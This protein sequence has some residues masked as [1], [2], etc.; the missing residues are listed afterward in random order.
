MPVRVLAAYVV[1][2][3]ARR[4]WSTCLTLLGMTAVV[5]AIVLMLMLARGLFTR[6]ADT[7]DP[8]NLLVI[9]KTGQSVILSSL[10]DEELALLVSLPQLARDVANRPLI[11]PELVQLVYVEVP[12]TSP[13]A[14]AP[15]TVRGIRPRALEVHRTLELVEGRMPLFAHEVMVGS[16]AHVKLG[17]PSSLL[18]PGATLR[19]EGITWTISGVFSAR[20]SLFE[21]E[22]WVRE[23][24]L[25]A[26]L[27]RSSHS[28]A[29]LRFVSPAAA[30]AALAAF[31]QSG[32]L[33]KTFTASREPDYYRTYAQA[34]QWVLWLAWAFV[35]AIAAAGALI[36]MNTMY[37]NVLARRREIATLRVLGF[38]PATLAG[39][40]AAEALLIS[41]GAATLGI[42]LGRVLHATPLAVAQGAFFL[43]FDSTVALLALALALLSGLVGTAFP[44][45][46]ILHGSIL[47][48]LRD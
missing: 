39:L 1:R 35:L 30:L 3:L 6:I 18:A 48:H 11:S 5:F 7:G 22:V 41:L 23:S 45:F 8:H 44:T 21:S 10:F 4:P 26:A 29:T 40:L 31:E 13:P 20:G 33:Q 14:G 46:R 43:H 42:G 9:S 27:Q 38:H 37:T 12:T 15:L 32:P 19:F 34:L 25:M 36:G 17:V 47:R 16:L 24:D 28:C 2:N